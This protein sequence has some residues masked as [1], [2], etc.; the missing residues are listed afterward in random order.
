MKKTTLSKSLSIAAI[1]TIALMS[2][3]VYANESGAMEEILV[4]ANKREQSIMDLAY[5]ISAISGEEIQDRGAINMMDIQFSVP[6]LNIQEFTPGV[7]RLQM[8]GINAGAGTGLPVVSTYVDEVGITID[9]QQRAGAFP[10]V[11]LERV[12]VLRGPQGTL[13]GESAMAGTIRYITRNPDLS[14]SDGFMEADV[15]SQ[16]E[17]DMGYSMNG[18]VG[19][20]IVPGKVGLRVSGGYNDRAGWI[21]YPQAGEEDTNGLSNWFVRPKLYAELSDDLT[22]SV[23]YQYFDQEMDGDS[24][25]SVDDHLVR[26]KSVLYPG[27]EKSHLLNAVI[28]YE[29]GDH[30]L[31][32]STGYQDREVMFT[33]T[34]GGGMFF[35]TYDESYEQFSQEFRLSSTHSGPIQYVAG[36][37]YRDFDS[38]VVRGSEPVYGALTRDGD[39]PTDSKSYAVFGEV[40]WNATEALEL[41]LGGRYY[42]D[43]RSTGSVIPVAADK[44]AEF[45]AFSPRFT[46]RYQVTPE[47]SAYFTASKGFRSG[48]FN[49]TGT[50]YDPEKIWNYEI[51]TKAF[52]LNETVMLDVAAYY[53]DYTDR[54]EQSAVPMGNGVFIA[55]TQNAGEASGY[56][57]ESTISAQLGNGLQLDVS[58]SWNDITSDIDTLTVSKG[59]R[60]DFVADFTGSV[61]LS[62]RTELDSGMTRHWRLDYQYSKPYST[63]VR[64][65]GPTGAV[66]TYQDWE[67]EN[68]TFLNARIGLETEQWE[69]SLYG[70]NLLNE[71]AMTFPFAP[72][73]ANN[74]GVYAAPRSVG[75]TMR[76]QF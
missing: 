40:T 33:T 26:G 32:S 41:S 71:D 14:E 47:A 27:E 75:V 12:E 35:V 43:E 25:A 65:A 20:P 38:N 53:S 7:F 61:S 17:G 49:G 28:E 19:V 9:Q 2:S 24:F 23:L 5:A 36:V 3:Q 69:L 30:M 67:S 4:T 18:A 68:Q 72:L 55:E 6:G 39:S 13:Y 42:D 54:Q 8:R 11:D 63:I 73:V 21:D 10:M 34:L 64:V 50:T 46:A 44:E 76:K 57:L 60:F 58:A 56:G 51:G 37:W 15:Y 16:S 48:G 29:F 74:E 66:V 22:V 45:D 62:Q 31:T 59:E 52:L 1:G 70:K